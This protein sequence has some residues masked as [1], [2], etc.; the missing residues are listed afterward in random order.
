[1]IIIFVSHALK[2]RHENLST[3]P[4]KKTKKTPCSKGCQRTICRPVSGQSFCEL[5]VD[6]SNSI[7]CLVC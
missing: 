3:K 1:V 6:G 7:S 4:G 2:Y 5:P